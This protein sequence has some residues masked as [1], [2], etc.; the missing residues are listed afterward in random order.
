MKSRGGGRKT[1]EAARTMAQAGGKRTW[2]GA[3][4]VMRGGLVAG[5]FLKVEP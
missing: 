4:E 2:L 3:V 5:I 1:R